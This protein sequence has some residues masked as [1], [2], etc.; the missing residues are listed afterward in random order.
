LFAEILAKPAV[1]DFDQRQ[2]KSVGE[3]VLMRAAE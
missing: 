3:A 2:G 1:L